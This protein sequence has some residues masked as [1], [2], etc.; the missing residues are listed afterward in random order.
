MKDLATLKA[1]L[2]SN[3]DTA[4]EYDALE[5]EFTLAHEMTDKELQQRDASRDIGAELLQAVR[6]VKAGTVGKVNTTQSHSRP[7]INLSK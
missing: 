6:D 1:Q 7:A 5:D 3:P 4:R 2:L